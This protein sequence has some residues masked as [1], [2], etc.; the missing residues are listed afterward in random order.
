MTKLRFGVRWQSAATTPLWEGAE[1]R[2]GRSSARFLARSRPHG[3]TLA[4]SATSRAPPAHPKAASSL[5]SAAA[6]QNAT[7]RHSCFVILSSFVIRHSSFSPAGKTEIQP[8]PMLAALPISNVV[9]PLG[10]LALSVAFIVAAIAV[11]RLHA[12]FS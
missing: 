12:F 6:L 7:V 5:R 2:G 3:Q 1:R 8:T 10:V 9:G 11:F 4:R